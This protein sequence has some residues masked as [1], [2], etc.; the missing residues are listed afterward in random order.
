MCRSFKIYQQ[1]VL[2]AEKFHVSKD[3][4]FVLSGQ[5]LEIEKQIR[6][7]GGSIYDPELISLA[8]K[9]IVEGKFH[10]AKIDRD[11]V[12]LLSG[13]AVIIEA[14]DGSEFIFGSLDVFESSVDSNFKS[15]GLDVPSDSKEET[16]LSMYKPTRSA[17]LRQ[18]FSAIDP[19]LNKLCLTQHQIKLFCRKHRR[20]LSHNQDKHN[21][22][23][24]KVGNRFFV[25]AVLFNSAVSMYVLLFNIHHPFIWPLI[26]VGKI[27]VPVM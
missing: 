19:D 16:A 22:F 20:L 14:C 8:L 12:R 9:D 17:T 18:M 3:L 7:K 1:G 24:I 6:A 13:E 25:V 21:F 4:Y 23:I 5:M 26:K 10:N 2:M 11:V 27:I 15:W